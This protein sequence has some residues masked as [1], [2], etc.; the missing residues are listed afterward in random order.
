MQIDV[1]DW[2]GLIFKRFLTNEIE[3]FFRIGSDWVALVQTQI[4][5]WFRVIRIGSEWIPHWNFR[6]GGTVKKSIVI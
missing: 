5:E 6:Q 2:G 1:S 4:S 3:N